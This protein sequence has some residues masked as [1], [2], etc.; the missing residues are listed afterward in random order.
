MGSGLDVVRHL[1]DHYLADMLRRF[2]SCDLGRIV[3]G[4]LGSAMGGNV[5]HL[6]TSGCGSGPRLVTGPLALP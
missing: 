6:M 3:S 5:R 2:G 1:L 4:G